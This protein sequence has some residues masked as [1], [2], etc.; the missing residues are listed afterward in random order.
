M[1]LTVTTDHARIRALV[2]PLLAADPVRNTVLG[3]ISITLED[4]AWAASGGD[5][6]A[7]RS[8]AEFP[9][10]LVGSWPVDDRDELLA[11]LLGLPE[12]AGISGPAPQVRPLLDVVGPDARLEHQRLF[13]LDRLVEPVA[14]GRAVIAGGEHRE[15]GRA[16]VAAFVREANDSMRSTDAMADRAI[17]QGQ[18]HLWLDPSGEP[19]SMACRRPVLAGSARI[20]P[21]YTP[22]EKRGH[23]CG[24]G[25]TASATRSIL[26]EGGIPTLFT[27]L[28]NPT[29]NKIYQAL[30]YY[31]VEDRI[32]ASRSSHAA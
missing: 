6:V 27:D 1:P 30:G 28:A 26:D 24:S 10:V 7:I 4:S 19:A 8:A 3:T 21:V 22:P 5:H 20:G 15:F 13:R 16:C 14:E 9:L 25:V 31:A 12:L 17:D 23:G 11:L 2:G 32:V 18:M 29:S